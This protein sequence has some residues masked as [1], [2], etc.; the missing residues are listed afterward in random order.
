[1]KA[2]FDNS[3]SVLTSGTSI[4]HTENKKL[5]REFIDADKAIN[6]MNSM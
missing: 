5:K 1:M 3:M 4:F 6:Y 2:G